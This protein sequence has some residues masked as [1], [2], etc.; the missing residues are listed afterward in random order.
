MEAKLPGSDASV[1]TAEQPA[2]K[3]VMLSV[4]GEDIIGAADVAMVVGAAAEPVF[5]DFESSPQAAS[6][7]VNRAAAATAVK[8]VVRMEEL[9]IVDFSVSTDSEQIGYWM[10]LI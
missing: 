4:E 9:L 1:G 6:D 8:R 5:S 3:F 10:G 2:P 7:T